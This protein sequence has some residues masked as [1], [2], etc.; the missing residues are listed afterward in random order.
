MNMWLQQAA[1]WSWQNSLAAAAMAA[2]V[3]AMRQI[4]RGRIAPRWLC[5]AGWLVMV[6]LFL[7][8][9]FSHP[10]AW[11][12]AWAVEEKE[13]PSLTVPA[14]Y[15]S[16]A[17]PLADLRGEVSTVRAELE[18]LRISVAPAQAAALEEMSDFTAPERPA[19]PAMI[20][21]EQPASVVH[22]AVAP[23][24][25]PVDWL[26]VSGW[27]WAAGSVVFFGSIVVRHLRF[28]RRLHCTATNSLTAGTRAAAEDCAALAGLRSIPPI[29]ITPGNGSPFLCGL[30]RPRIVL[31]SDTLAALSS[32][33]LRHVLLHEMLHI[34]R[35]DLAANWGLAIAC[36][37]HWWNPFIHFTAR[38]LLADR[39]LLRDHEAIALL[40]DPAERA[41]YGH[42][43]LK[44]A[45]PVAAPAL[46]PGLAPLFRSEKELKRR[47]IMI[48]SP[49]RRPRLSAC[50]AAAVIAS[51]SVPV[52]ST[53]GGQEEKKADAAASADAAPVVPADPE[54]AKTPP[55]SAL[56]SASGAAV[57]P[58]SAGQSD[59]LN[60]LIGQ[61]TVLKDLNGEQLIAG[62]YAIGDNVATIAKLYPEYQQEMVAVGSHYKSGFGPR[63]PKSLGLRESMNIKRK[64]LDLAAQNY[65]DGLSVRIAAAQA[66]SAPAPSILDNLRV[67]AGSLRDKGQTAEAAAIES[68]IKAL[69]DMGASTVMDTPRG[70]VRLSTPGMNSTQAKVIQDAVRSAYGA[71]ASDPAEAPPASD[72]LQQLRA[73][74][75]EMRKSMATLQ[76]KSYPNNP[77]YVINIAEKELSRA[78]KEGY[79]SKHPRVAGL[80]E[81]IR[82]TKES[83]A[84]AKASS[85]AEDKAMEAAA[86][87]AEAV[88]NAE[89]TGDDLPWGV[90]VVG[91]TGMVYSPYSP[92]SSIVDVS[93]QKNG[94]TVK[95]PYT[96]KLF[97]VP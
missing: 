18:A 45:L 40:H 54:G 2:A 33:E 13:V 39:E 19:A 1:L 89:K 59:D 23:R 88:K 76:I 50:T 4:W 91:K 85:I 46:S 12:R 77:D 37:L 69:R 65:V 55:N 84:A 61:W 43:L 57:A 87:R 62:V 86:P 26:A 52:F 28:V 67:I 94:D 16:Q 96:G 49:L 63:H 72:E 81:T 44:L 51:I 32:G 71:P 25:T 47:L 7:P 41:A 83:Q 68:E 48:Q 27:V 66:A 75:A 97:R 15:E 17:T 6:R 92:E 82:L 56:D 29:C 11:D 74:M 3:M 78:S 31:P 36:A 9:P 34:A 35:R 21:S 22:A 73:E 24:S 90:P 64:Q 95:C 20:S 58:P 80:R 53:A 70:T 30:L 8:A 93:E 79:G 14:V 42:T 38:R 60:K 5:L 10:W